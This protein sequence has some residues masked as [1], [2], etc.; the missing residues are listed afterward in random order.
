MVTLGALMDS[1]TLTHYQNLFPADEFKVQEVI[2]QEYLEY[3]A[4]VENSSLV[5]CLKNFRFS[6]ESELYEQAELYMANYYNKVNFLLV[7][8]SYFIWY[9]LNQ[10]PPYPRVAHSQK[11]VW[12]HGPLML[13]ANAYPVLAF[14]LTMQNVKLAVLS[15]WEKS[16]YVC[17]LISYEIIS[18]SHHHVI[19]TLRLNWKA[20]DMFAAKVYLKQLKRR[21]RE[22]LENRNQPANYLFNLRI[23]F[24]DRHVKFQLRIKILCL[25]NLHAF[26]DSFQ[27]LNSNN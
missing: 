8:L 19:T 27:Q 16:P 4:H 1:F 3:G 6:E 9:S 12:Q 10:C 5:S 17:L 22:F 26:K 18:W 13:T 11:D 14:A 23:H 21:I 7:F 24:S 20:Y 15:M 25:L 2:S